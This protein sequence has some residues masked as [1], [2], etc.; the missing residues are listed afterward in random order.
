MN[1]NKAN[2]ILSLPSSRGSLRFTELR[3]RLANPVLTFPLK[4][5]GRLTVFYEHGIALFKRPRKW[6]KMYSSFL[7]EGQRMGRNEGTRLGMCKSNPILTFPLKWKGKLSV[8]LR[9]H[10]AMFYNATQ[11]AKDVS[12]LFKGRT[13]DGSVKEQNMSSY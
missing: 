8:F 2:P 3:V 11:V 9:T 10:N 4:W 7:R 6:Q 12:F 5:K 1:I 13:K